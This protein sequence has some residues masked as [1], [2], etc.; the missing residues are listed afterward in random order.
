[1]KTK[2]IMGLIA[3][4]IVIIFISIIFSMLQSPETTILPEQSQVQQE[5]IVNQIQPLIQQVISSQRAITVIDTPR[6]KKSATL[7]SVSEESKKEPV[8]ESYPSQENMAPA[9]ASA[10]EGAPSQSQAGITIINKRPTP[11]QIKE[12]NTKGIIIY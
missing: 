1:M 3:L 2:L 11:E 4:L 12:M 5:Q 8:V 10:S 6:K 9:F 7:P